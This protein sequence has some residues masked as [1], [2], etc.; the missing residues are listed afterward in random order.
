M[1][2]LVSV[3][4]LAAP[5]VGSTWKGTWAHSSDLVATAKA[6][7]QKHKRVSKDAMSAALTVRVE[8][9]NE[10]RPTQVVVDAKEFHTGPF[11]IRDD[12]GAVSVVFAK[13]PRI[14]AS[15]D[16]MRTFKATFGRLVLDDPEREAMATC[17]TAGV[18]ATERWLMRTSATLFHGEVTETKLA[19]VKVK[20]AA[21]KGRV[22]YDVAWEAEVPVGM[23]VYKFNA[24][25]TV[26]VDP[27]VWVTGWSFGGPLAIDS[28]NRFELKVK[29]TF[30]SQFELKK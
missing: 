5:T 20:C 18:A 2:A 29:G 6:A 30:T 13:P 27:S 21:K 25:G 28:D 8:S 23:A 16:L 17:N 22:I 24:A 1:N 19:N 15:P 12:G 7:G 10:R 11:S 9:A 3:L 4:L 14:P 26:T